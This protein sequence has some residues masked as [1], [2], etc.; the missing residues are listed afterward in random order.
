M[1][2]FHK[3]FDI[4]Q[5]AAVD[6][7]GVVVPSRYMGSIEGLKGVKGDARITAIL[8]IGKE[9]LLITEIKTPQGYDHGVVSLD[10]SE[11]T[12]VPHKGALVLGRE[13]VGAASAEGSVAEDALDQRVEL[14]Y[15][16]DTGDLV[17][18]SLD[19]GSDTRLIVSPAER[20]SREVPP[21]AELLP[22]SDI[23]YSVYEKPSKH[24]GDDSHMILPEYSVMAVFDGVGSNER[25][26]EAAR[27]SARYMEHVYTQTEE[28]STRIGQGDPAAVCEWLKHLVNETS[29]GIYGD[30]LGMTTA[31]VAQV[32]QHEGKTYVSWANLG[33]SRLYLKRGPDV[34]ALTRDDGDGATLTG[35]VGLSLIREA[36]Q[37]G[38]TEVGKGDMLIACTDGITGDYA[39]D[40]MTSHEMAHILRGVETPGEATQRL[41]EAS[42]KNDD[43]TVV[44][45]ALS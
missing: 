42:R 12:P 27:T 20:S 33:D 22:V 11:L 3:R 31:S 36:H 25:G 8:G 35:A 34:Y 23:D 43:K 7:E 37:T 24:G 19:P 41:M 28:L 14:Y 16:Y 26:G 40:M 1:A 38:Y 18:R 9:A 45:A 21:S 5:P 2:K 13:S 4:G 17:C 15:D 10:N 29:R 32:V 44:V 30:Q 39:S 6:T